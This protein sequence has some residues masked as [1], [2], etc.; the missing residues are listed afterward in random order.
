MRYRRFGKLDWEASILGFGVMRLPLIDNKPGEFN[1][2]ES[3][4]MI[5]YAIDRGVNYLDA[6]YPYDRGQDER[7]VRILGRALQDGYREKVKIAATLPPF[8]INSRADFDRCLNDRIQRLETEKIDF[9]LLGWLNRENWPGLRELGVL[10][11]A[12]QAMMDGRIDKLGFSFHDDFQGLRTVLEDY[13]GW[14]FCEFQYSYMDVNHHPGTGGIKYV[15]D[16]GL[17]VVVTEPLRGGRLTK[18]PPPQVAKVWADYP[19]SQERSPA[20]WGLRWVWNHPEVS[21]VV[22]DMGSMGQVEENIA[23]ADRAEPD[24]LSVREVVMISHVREAYNRLKPV[25]CTACRACMPCPIGIDVPRIFEIYNDA[26]I[27]ED[28]ETGRDIYKIEGHS[29]ESCN[30]C[31]ACANSCAKGLDLISYLKKACELLA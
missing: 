1:E 20:E 25:P 10:A 24:S 19:V 8:L 30:E 15:A 16:M 27:Y 21:V 13:D 12:E 28:I 29:A 14:S 3:I 5:R 31:D 4:R 18:S 2:P 23:S 11:R 17:A 26:V 9:C 22:S 7:R 6:G